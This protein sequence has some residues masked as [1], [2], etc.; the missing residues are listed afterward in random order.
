M[1]IAVIGGKL[2]GVEATFL[3]H[4]AGWEVRRV[5]SL[6]VRVLHPA[7]GSKEHPPPVL[8][9]TIGDIQI[10]EVERTEKLVEA[11]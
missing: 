10:L 4:K 3:A 6:A 9:R 11:A 2:Q 8:L 5:V 1:R 7:A